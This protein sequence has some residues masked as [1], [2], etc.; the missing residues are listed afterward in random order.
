[1]RKIIFFVSIYVI[2]NLSGCK[3]KISDIFI[4]HELK[5]NYLTANNSIDALIRELKDKKIIVI[6]EDYVAVNEQLFIARNIT[7]MYDAG[8][9]YIFFEGGALIGNS[10]PGSP[11]YN[12]YMFYP[13]MPVG[14]S[15]EDIAL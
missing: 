6:G 10:L 13:W 5:T 11:N 14:W 3:N 7:K 15:Y 12:F 4:N 1:M 8:V 9:R 2:I